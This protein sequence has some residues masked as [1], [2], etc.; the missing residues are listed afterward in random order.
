MGMALPKR[1]GYIYLRTLFTQLS[2]FTPEFKNMVCACSTRKIHRRVTQLGSRK[3]PGAVTSLGR[4]RLSLE[5]W[6]QV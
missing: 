6:G 1:I 5:S 2:N 3:K 4:F